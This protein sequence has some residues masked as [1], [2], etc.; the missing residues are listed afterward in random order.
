MTRAR[1]SCLRNASG[2]QGLADSRRGECRQRGGVFVGIIG[3]QPQG[4]EGYVA[5]GFPLVLFERLPDA[6]KHTGAPFG[7]PNGVGRRFAG[8]KSWSKFC[9][10]R[11]TA[12]ATNS[13]FFWRDPGQEGKSVTHGLHDS[14]RTCSIGFDRGEWRVL[15]RPEFC[16]IPNILRAPIDLAAKWHNDCNLGGSMSAAFVAMEEIA[17]AD[18]IDRLARRRMSCFHRVSTGTDGV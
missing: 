8:A 11:R 18:S 14:E 10:R 6:P 13:Q 5:R 12:P 2:A 17:K 1:L 4:R 9:P 7:D 3:R 16:L 15:W